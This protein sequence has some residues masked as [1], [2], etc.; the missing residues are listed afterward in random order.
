MQLTTIVKEIRYDR[1]THD[2]RMELDGRLV[3]YAPTH[4]DAEVRLDQMVYDQLLHQPVVS[5]EITIK[6]G[7]FIVNQ[8]TGRTWQRPTPLTVTATRNQD[9]G[10]MEFDVDGSRFYVMETSD[11][12]VAA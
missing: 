7:A 10:C 12:E 8:E 3:G 2:Y 4:H 5:E 1:H 9:S 6:A 11:Y